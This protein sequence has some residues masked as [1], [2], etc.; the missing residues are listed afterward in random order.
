MKNLVAIGTIVS[1]I[2]LT[3]CSQE[4][5]Q[6]SYSNEADVKAVEHLIAEFDRCAREG[7]LETF[8]SYS[9]DDV[10]FL[11]PNEP[12]IVGKDVMRPWYENFYATFNIDMKH[13]HIE[14]HSFDD[15]V[16]HRGD[17]TGTITPKVGGEPIHFNNK[18][19]YVLRRQTDGSLKVWRAAFNSNT[20]PPQIDK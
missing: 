3:T 13:E 4:S 1:L 18:Y 6:S 2:I 11:A 15:V 10:V 19:L 17:C 8:L 20:P 14:T 9:M 12:A 7:D 16:I 5:K